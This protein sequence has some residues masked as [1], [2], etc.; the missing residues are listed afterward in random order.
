MTTTPCVAG[1]LPARVKK[2]E[3][4]HGKFE[5]AY[6][7]L[8]DEHNSTKAENRRL[9]QEL[10]ELKQDVLKQRED[11]NMKT[12]WLT[13]MLSRFYT[14]QH[15]AEARAATAGQLDLIYRQN[16]TTNMRSKVGSQPGL[17]KQPTQAQLRA[18]EPA[19]TKLTE[20]VQASDLDFDPI[21]SNAI[22]PT[23]ADQPP[24]KQREPEVMQTKTAGIKMIPTHAAGAAMKKYS[25]QELKQIRDNDTTSA[26]GAPPLPLQYTIA[27][28][29]VQAQI[30]LFEA[31]TSAVAASAAST[32]TT[33]ALD[34]LT[35]Y[36]GT[37]DRRVGSLEISKQVLQTGIA[38][39]SRHVSE[40][41]T[42]MS[43]SLENMWE[44]AQEEASR[45]QQQLD[46]MRKDVDLLKKGLEEM[47]K[48]DDKVLEE[49]EE[50]RKN[51]AEVR[52][53]LDRVRKNEAKVQLELDKVREDDTK[54][55][56]DL[57]D[58]WKD[59]K[60][61]WKEI[62]HQCDE[63]KDLDRDV[64]RL[65][66]SRDGHGRE[67]DGIHAHLRDVQRRRQDGY[68]SDSRRSGCR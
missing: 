62:D 63:F 23:H 32:Q 48:K 60:L 17:L 53:K 19:L 55:R 14:D 40:A 68:G 36:L 24:Q 58:V 28:K 3:E 43:G 64:R 51:E 7:K 57:G 8:N 46:D 31:K 25:Q 42:D 29:A 10:D 59:I 26:H 30:A 33:Q 15:S 54:L 39:M 6:H 37:V 22:T 66:D 16:P 47:G 2:L 35:H 34:R 4:A 49:L 9:K 65:M 52:M 18:R 27:L 12:R 13:A 44:N 56:N 11:T 1:A 45:Q 41:R 50:V 61:V 67:L 20:Q 21:A 38:T 5:E